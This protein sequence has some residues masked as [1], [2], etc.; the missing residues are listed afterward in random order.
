MSGRENAPKMKMWWRN[1]AVEGERGGGSSPPGLGSVILRSVACSVALD[2][3]AK[4][5][6]GASGGRV[7]NMSPMLQI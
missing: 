7:G 5:E 3:D 2:A 1:G 6:L 4:F